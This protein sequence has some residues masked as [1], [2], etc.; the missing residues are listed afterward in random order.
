MVSRYLGWRSVALRGFFTRLLEWE[1]PDA[2]ARVPVLA[3]DLPIPDEPL[4]RFLDDAAA[5]KL[6]QA[7]ADEDPVV[8]LAVEF[9]A[10][11]GMRKGEFLALT[12]DAV[13][14]IGAA[15][16]LHVPVGKLHTDRYIPL[17][18][19][20]KD[21]LD[22]WL[23]RRPDGLRSKLIFLEQGRPMPASRVDAAVAKAAA[24]AGIGHV[25]PHQLR[26]T[27]ATQAINRGMSLEAIA[28]LLGHR[29]LHMTLVYAKIADRTVAEPTA[30]SPPNATAAT[31]ARASTPTS[32]GRSCARTPR[33][34][35]P[36][37]R[38]RAATPTSPR[39]CGSRKCTSPTVSGS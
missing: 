25:S 28:A 34:S 13:V 30:G 35:R 22:G 37:C 32:S 1:I 39:T 2:P 24:T 7:R 27:L 8:R 3:S 29:S 18:P 6:L 20:L 23:A 17:H 19:Q 31:C 26:H 33:R 14:Q 21:L 4:P 5:T 11:T 38:G 15:Y 10:R 12:T 9:L 36:P 16:W